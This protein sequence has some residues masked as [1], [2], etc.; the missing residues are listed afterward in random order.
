MAEQ[1]PINP[2]VLV[3]ARERAGLSLEDAAQKFKRMADW[4][5]GASSPTYPQ[6]ELLADTFKIPV[7]VF[8]FPE[9]PDVPSINE[10]FR[11]LP[12]AEL[13]RLPSRMRLLM[14]KAKAMQMNLA[15]LTQ[16]RNPADRLITRDL[17]FATGVDIAKMAATVRSYIGVS[18]EEQQSWRGDD[19][20]LKEWR[21]AL[22]NVGVFVFKDAFRLDD[23]SG[24]CLYDDEFPV[25]YVNNSSTKTRQIFTYFHELAHLIFHTSGI[26]KV[27]DGYIARLTGD[28]RQ[29]EVIC[30]SL[31]AQVL[32]P[33]GAFQRAMADRPATEATAEVLAAQF[34]V[35]R[36]VIF[37]RLLDQG[38]IGEPQYLEAVERWNAQR[39]AGAG[40]GGSSGNHYWTKLSYLGRDYVALALSQF[41]QNRIDEDQLAEYLDTK[42]KNVGTLE[43][44][45]ARG[46]V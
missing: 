31:A 27:R 4:E 9:P 16:G 34:N 30:N 21:A 42:P 45:F 7:A 33:E 5:A 43:D 11:T 15:E 25:I 1:I 28:A 36:E 2:A 22:L 10:T 29:I 39:Q 6:L 35:S 24:F 41:H 40:E 26:D 19:A 23:F 13:E 8:F 18:V 3:W 14:R 32:V 17:Q 12:E 37:R 38:R 46:N 20:A 44:Y